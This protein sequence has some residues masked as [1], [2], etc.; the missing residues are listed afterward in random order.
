MLAYLAGGWVVQNIGW[1]EAFFIVGVPGLLLA[2]IVKTTVVE[3]PRGL[4]ENRR[5]SGE[6]PPLFSVLRFLLARRSFLHMAVGAG[7]TSFTGYSVVSFFPSFIVRS[8]EMEIVSLGLWLGLILGIAGGM[9]FFGGGYLADLFGRVRQRNGLWFIATT[10][11]VTAVSYVGVFLAPTATWCLVIF[12]IPAM[13]SNFYLAPVLAQTQGL[14]PLRMRGVAAAIMLLI[15]NMIGLG[16]GPLVVGAISDGLL[17]RF[18][19]DS[20]RY[21]LMLVCATL[22][23]WAS[24]HYFQAA[25]FIEADLARVGD[26]GG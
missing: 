9:G 1:R 24:L 17:P 26:A 20:L 5:D 22:L 13:I 21:S 11:L 6:H 7:L 18:G 15:L 14:V 23:P 16:L 19:D 4:S 12:I 8:Y 3:P 2:V 10:Q 25:K